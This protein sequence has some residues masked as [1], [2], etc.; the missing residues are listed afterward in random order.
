MLKTT[1]AAILTTMILSGTAQSASVDFVQ[2]A[3]GNERGLVNGTA[4]DFDG[5]SVTFNALTNSA[6][7]DDKSSG[8]DGGLGVCKILNANDQC[9]PSNDDNL[10]SGEMVELTFGTTV[11]L[12]GFSFTNQDHNSL[13]GS[14][15]NLAVG[16]N[17]IAPSDRTFKSVVDGPGFFGVNSIRFAYAE[18]DSSA[19]YVNSFTATPT[20]PVPLPAAAL[21]LIGGVGALGAVARNRQTA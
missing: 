4:L 6:Y 18:S 14:L 2:E 12:T 16:I 21:L 15:L 8:K 7:L 9:N 13:N 10:A 3:A 1:C 20:A 11:D 19:Y 17:G 5:L